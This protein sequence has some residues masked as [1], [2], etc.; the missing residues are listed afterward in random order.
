MDC[1]PYL[2]VL[3]YLVDCNQFIAYGTVMQLLRAIWSPFA[4]GGVSHL[5]HSTV[6]GNVERH[7]TVAGKV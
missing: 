5:C 7:C 1:N 6:G 4:S 3:E 2:I